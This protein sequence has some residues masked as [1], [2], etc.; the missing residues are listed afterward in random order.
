MN[1]KHLTIIG[2]AAVLGL[3]GCR[4]V[5]TLEPSDRVNPPR[6]INDKR[7]TT[8]PSLQRRVAVIAVNEAE[9]AGGHLR[10]QVEVRNTTR[11]Y[12]RFSYKFEWF[13]GDGILVELPTGGYRD[14]Q[15]E[16]GESRMLVAVA[17]TA[18][19][20][21]FRLQLIENVR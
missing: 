17:P 12:R 4:S 18:E 3:G 15:L 7:V 13:D 16:G 20:K 8:D 21:D 11:R 1:R 10:I 5:N 14:S 6:E 19:A 2:L 9:G